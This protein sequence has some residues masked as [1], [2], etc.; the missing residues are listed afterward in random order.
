[1]GDGTTCGCL[2]GVMPSR[3]YERHRP[4]GSGEICP[5]G[6]RKPPHGPSALV[7]RTVPLSTRISA[8]FHTMMATRD[9]PSPPQSRGAGAVSCRG[10]YSIWL[11]EHG[12]DGADV[13]AQLRVLVF[14][15]FVDFV[16]PVHH[17]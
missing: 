14:Q 3:R 1:M 16:V 15:F 17:R 10:R 6:D 7:H 8:L 12:T 4:C 9:S 13:T 11:V 2:G 5:Q